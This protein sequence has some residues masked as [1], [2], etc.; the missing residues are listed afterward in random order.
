VFGSR[1]VFIGDMLVNSPSTFTIT[2][3]TSNSTPPGR[4]EIPIQ[5]TYYDN[6]RTLYTI[7][8]SIPVFII[9]GQQTTAARPAQQGSVAGLPDIQW[10][11]Y[12]AII[13]L[14]IGIYMGKR[15][16]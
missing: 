9:G 11:Y 16:R 6:L 7:N 15:F 10:I 5:I 2:L 13:S 8:I 3:I 12:I 14:V 1:S 4:Y